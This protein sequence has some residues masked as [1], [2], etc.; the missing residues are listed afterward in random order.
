MIAI[1]P[2][3]H[4]I[5]VHFTI[6]LLAIATLLFVVSAVAGRGR[7]MP[8]VE[9]AAN[10]NLWLGA[11]L[12]ALTIAAGLQAAGSVAHDDAAHLAM[13]DHKLWALSTAGLFMLLALWNALRVRRAQGVGSAFV[14]LMLVALVGLAGTGLRGADLVFRHG[15]GVM[16]LPQVADEGVE[17]SHDEPAASAGTGDGPSDGGGGHA[18]AGAATAAPMTTPE[19]SPVEAEVVAVLTAYHAALTAGDAAAPEQFVVA[20]ERFLMFEGK[21]VNQ[22]WAEYR[23]HHLKDELGD[24]A[25]VRFRLSGYRVQMDGALAVVSFIFNVLPKTGPE[26]DFGSGRATAVLLRTESGWKLQRLHTS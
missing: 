4:P 2:N 22:G 11:A 12:T 16:S 15:L 25:Q 17:H 13:E 23:D 6:A 21:Y 7:A 18:P 24:L 3:W 20:D 10:W 8:G 14:A 1:I 26:M 19:L 9:A 5:L